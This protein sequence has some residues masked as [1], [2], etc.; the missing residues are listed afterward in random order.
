MK[1]LTFAA[2][3]TLSLSIAGAN[4]VVVKTS[5]QTDQYLQ[6]R[7]AQSREAGKQ[8]PMQ[9]FDTDTD[10]VVVKTSAQTN[11]YLQQRDAQSREAGKQRQVQRVDNRVQ[12]IS[13]IKSGR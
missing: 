9:Q 8:R 10:T 2:L 4:T 7:D 1:K 6:Q 13:S 12:A 11:Q 5:D 3:A